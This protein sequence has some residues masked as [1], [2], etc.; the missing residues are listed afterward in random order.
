V[1]SDINISIIINITDITG[2]TCTMSMTIVF[3]NVSATR[4]SDTVMD[5]IVDILHPLTSCQLITTLTQTD[6]SKLASEL[7]S[8]DRDPKGVGFLGT[9]QLTPFPTS[10][11]SGE[12]CC[13]LPQWGP[14]Q[15]LGHC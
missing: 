11:G 5:F 10:Y 3:V 12:R 4:D 2:V 13:K 14:G 15:S 1:T 6:S 8:E 9:E 7:G